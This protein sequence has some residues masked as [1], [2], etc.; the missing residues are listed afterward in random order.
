[1]VIPQVEISCEQKNRSGFVMENN[2]EDPYNSPCPAK[3]IYII[4]QPLEVVSRYRDP[5]PQIVGNYSNICYI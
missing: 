1:M 4:F 3:L 5:Q 2:I